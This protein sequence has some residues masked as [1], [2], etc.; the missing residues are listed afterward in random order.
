MNTQFSSTAREDNPLSNKAALVKSSLTANF[1]W[2]TALVRTL[3]RADYLMGKLAQEMSHLSPLFISS[4]LLRETVASARLDGSRATLREIFLNNAGLYSS[5][6]MGGE[7]NR[8]L[9]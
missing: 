6:S 2:S 7:A 9:W 8:E 1:E 4:L 3:S 5:L